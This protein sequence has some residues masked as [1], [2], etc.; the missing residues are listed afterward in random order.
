[1]PFVWSKRFRVVQQPVYEVIPEIT[2]PEFVPEVIAEEAV[3][4][5]TQ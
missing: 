3:E 1:M 4:E 2:I 5:E